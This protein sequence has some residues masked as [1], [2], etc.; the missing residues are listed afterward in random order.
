[1]Q[2]RRCYWKRVIRKGTAVSL[3]SAQEALY[4]RTVGRE[5][6]FR[7]DWRAEAEFSLLEAVTKE[8]LVKTQ[9][10]GKNLAGAVVVFQLWRLTVAL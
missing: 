8:Q 9:K 1:M 4:K 5:P 7:E 2:Q 3:R 6:P 10:A